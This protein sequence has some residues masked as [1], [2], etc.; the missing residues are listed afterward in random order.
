MNGI[1]A[2]NLVLA[3]LAENGPLGKLF[4]EYRA[5]GQ[6]IPK[7]IWDKLFAD[8]AEARQFLVDAITRAVIEGR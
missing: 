7:E 6:P 5:K 1:V 3:L 8:N 4:D 2:V